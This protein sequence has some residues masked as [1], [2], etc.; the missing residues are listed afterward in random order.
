MM[1]RRMVLK[2]NQGVL[3]TGREGE[4]HLFSFSRH[5]VDGELVDLATRAV[6]RDGIVHPNRVYSVKP[7]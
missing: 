3:W 2:D 4:R 6:A 7:A 1:H 5:H